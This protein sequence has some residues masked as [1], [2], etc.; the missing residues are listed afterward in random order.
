[1]PA[2][3]DEEERL[4]KDKE[5][6]SKRKVKI[7]KTDRPVSPAFADDKKKVVSSKANDNLRAKREQEDRRDHHKSKKDGAARPTK[8]RNAA[9]PRTLPV[10]DLV[11]YPAPPTVELSPR[12]EAIKKSVERA[13]K[14]KR[15]SQKQTGAERRGR[16]DEIGTRKTLKTDALLQGKAQFVRLKVHALDRGRREHAP[17]THWRSQH[18][19]L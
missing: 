1:M 3:S 19:T 10:F 17:V 9:D 15:K 14:N 4:T 16:D 11:E 13:H 5:K 6:K 18:V 8:T 7:E 2:S 12:L